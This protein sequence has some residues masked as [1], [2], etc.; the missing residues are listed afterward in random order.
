MHPIIEASIDKVLADLAYR[1]VCEDER[2]ARDVK[3]GS[4]VEK[5][6][7]KVVEQWE[8][9]GYTEGGIAC[10]SWRRAQVIIKNRYNLDFYPPTPYSRTASVF[11]NGLDDKDVYFARAGNGLTKIGMSHSVNNRIIALKREVAPSDLHIIRIIPEGGR[12][13][14]QA[15]HHEFR[16]LRAC[17]EWFFLDMDDTIITEL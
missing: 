4:M 8:R 9:E 7:K 13:M 16:H 6:Q 5:E 17:G 15:L 11:M 10:F 2:Q 3:Y 1:I 12:S 14:E